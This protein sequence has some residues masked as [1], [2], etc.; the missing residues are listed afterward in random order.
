MG[1]LVLSRKKL[2]FRKKNWVFGDWS[3]FTKGSKSKNSRYK[4]W[5]MGYLV[6][7][8]KKLDFRK[9]AGFLEIGPRF[10]FFRMLYILINHLI[11]KYNHISAVV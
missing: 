3:P 6:L 4:E 10:T 9:K 11:G 1:Y 2:D 8:R 7:S 5:E